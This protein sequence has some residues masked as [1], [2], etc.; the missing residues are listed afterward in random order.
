MPDPELSNLNVDLGPRLLVVGGETLGTCD[1]MTIT[2]AEATPE[3]LEKLKSANEI[4]LVKMIG[5]GGTNGT[6]Y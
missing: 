3:E 2:I 5:E 1:N 4:R 6:D